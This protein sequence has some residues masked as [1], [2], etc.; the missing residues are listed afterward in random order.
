MRKL[1]AT[2]AAAAL[3]ACGTSSNNGTSTGSANGTGGT[4]GAATTGGTGGGSSGGS[5][6]ASGG[7]PITGLN[8]M[9]WTWVP[10]DGAICRDGSATGIGVNLNPN[11][12][13]LMIFLE[14]GGACFNIV[15]CADN[16]STVPFGASEFQTNFGPGALEASAG[17]FNR[18]DPANPMADWSFVYV[19][20]CTGDIHGGNAPDGGTSDG[21]GPE[22]FVG[23]HNM[24]LDLARLVPTFTSLNEVLLTGVSAGGFGA[25]LNY[26]QVA[27]AFSGVP[28][29]LLDDSGPPMST[30]YLAPCLQQEVTQDWNLGATVVAD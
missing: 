27:A 30:D 4:T 6:G 5:T 17:V 7:T 9:Q 15:T 14:G 2:L 21:V 22:A 11:S 8:P 24:T 16:D 1:A 18:S 10:I 28:V 29:E 25:L 13:K 3:C 23:Y 19:P 20:Y 12:N 26:D